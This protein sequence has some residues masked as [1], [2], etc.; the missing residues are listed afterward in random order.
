MQIV[1][2]VLEE[3]PFLAGERFTLGDIPLG[4]SLYRYFELQIDRPALP[5]VEAWYA[6]LK[7][8]PAYRE[9]VMI[10]FDDLKGRLAF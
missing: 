10:P 1:E 6:R 9:H 4:A 5:R 3:R 7:D 2:G 8:R